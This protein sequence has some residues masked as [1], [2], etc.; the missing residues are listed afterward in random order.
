[1]SEM[2][3][4]ALRVGVRVGGRSVDLLTCHLKSKLL[5]FPG[6]RFAP[7]DEGERARVGV[8]ALYRRTAEAATVRGC[9]VD[10]RGHPLVQQPRAR[11]RR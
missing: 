5:T 9:A 11:R 3:R 6:G 1:M 8:Y 10:L 2:G 7:R 4:G